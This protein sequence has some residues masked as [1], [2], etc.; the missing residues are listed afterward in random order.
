MYLADGGYS[1]RGR[2]K[3]RGSHQTRAYRLPETDNRRSEI[4]LQISKLD[5]TRFPTSSDLA[6]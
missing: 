3:G 4:I 6:S 2:G 1:Y 5:S